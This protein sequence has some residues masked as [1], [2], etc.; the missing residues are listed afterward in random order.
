MSERTQFETTVQLWYGC[1]WNVLSV[2]VPIAKVRHFPDGTI[3]R[4]TIEKVQRRER[5][6]AG[7]GREE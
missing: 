7:R 1:N 2:D 4:V 6:A 5:P 3:V